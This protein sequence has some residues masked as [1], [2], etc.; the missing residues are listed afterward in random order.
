MF[1]GKK[2]RI[3]ISREIGSIY[4]DFGLSLLEDNDG[5]RV[6][7]MEYKHMGNVELIIIEILREWATG[8]GRKPVSW[9]TLIE[10]LRESHLRILARK[11]EAELV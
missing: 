9:K 6:R 7:N 11:I 2:G 8:R 10:V 3:N 4:R 5:S 1:H